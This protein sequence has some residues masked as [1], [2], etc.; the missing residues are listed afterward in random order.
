MTLPCS[1]GSS[2][3]AARTVRASSRRA[4][5]TSVRSRASKRSSMPSALARR[6]SC[7]VLRR[8]ASMARWCTMPSTQV[9][10]LPRS[11]W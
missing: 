5:S 1:S 7:T 8:S 11:A 4:T 3:S 10:T 9:R 6:L 2:S